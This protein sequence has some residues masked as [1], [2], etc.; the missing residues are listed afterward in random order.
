MVFG[1]RIVLTVQKKRRQAKIGLFFPPLHREFLRQGDNT[2]IRA[3]F[4]FA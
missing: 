3:F 1:D 4:V 2:R